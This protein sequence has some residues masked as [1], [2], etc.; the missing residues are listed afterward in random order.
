MT[1]VAIAI[2]ELNDGG[3]QTVESISNRLR[4][5]RGL[6]EHKGLLYFKFRSGGS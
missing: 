3:Y 5:L 4:P 2:A 6:G 1:L